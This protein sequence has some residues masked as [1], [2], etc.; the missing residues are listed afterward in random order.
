MSASI[1]FL[2]AALGL[3]QGSTTGTE[4]Q[5]PEPQAGASGAEQDASQPADFESEPPESGAP[6][7]HQEIVVTAARYEQDS[8]ETPAP[9]S[10]ISREELERR[11]PEKL[12][13][14][15]KSLPGIEV[16]GEGPFRGL[17]VIRG[18]TSNRILI[19][20]DGQRLNNG[21]ESTEFAGIQPGLVDLSQ[22]E[23][24]EVLRGP[25]SVLYGSD[26]LGGVVNIIT[27]ES[28]FR[29][30]GFRLRGGG[31]YS[32]GS[33]ADT[34]RGRVQLGGE[35]ARANFLI[36]ATYFDAENYES[37]EGE[38]PNSQAT[39]HSFDATARFMLAENRFVRTDL[40]LFRARDIGF[41]GFDPATS[42]VDIAFPKFER[43]KFS[44]T[45]EVTSWRALR[46]LSANFYYQNT[47]KDTKRNFN[48]GPFFFSNN[49]TQSD[50]D[51]VGVN[52]QSSAELGAHRLTFGVDFYRDSL[53]DETFAESTFGSSTNV[54]VPDSDQ[55]AVGVFVQ[56]EFP[57]GGRLHLVVGARADRFSFV[58][59]DD[60]DYT[61][62]PFDETQSDISGNFGARYL[63]TDHVELT[64]LVGR[65]FRAPNI[66]ERS[67]FGL[68]TTGDT[69]IEQNPNL[70]SERS[71]NV[72][73]G[74]KV[75]YEKYFGGFSYFHNSIRDLI[76]TV[77]LG[78]DPNSGLQLA[79]FDNIDEATIQGV[80]LELQRFLGPR[81]SV[82][83]NFSYT[84]GTNETSGEPLAL[85]PPVKLVAGGRYQVRSWWGEL[86]GRLVSDQDRV[87]SALEPSE[88][89]T[90]FDVR[91]GYDLAD[92]VGL[93]IALEN[94]ADEAYAEPFNERLEPGR[95]LRVSL[96][97]NF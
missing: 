70:D 88:S 94:L 5:D 79:R 59:Q 49:R 47:F 55:D 9:I 61:G 29:S 1:W 67:F 40:Q 33:S 18:L 37:P 23:R 75:R 58:S 80:E 16:S 71:I 90:T 74:F 4:E 10:V 46:N 87:P 86:T 15:L 28:A 43:D 7:Y 42:G 31:S 50:I 63:V 62:L 38:V 19:L 81:W 39:Q 68:A 65:G 24:I 82:F 34:Q 45:Y 2:T 54:A 57:L 89:F 85:I 96:N 26:A 41:P 53:H 76:A 8:F 12:V 22:V 48:F 95:N 69:F 66:Q 73:V 83:T 35:G 93:Q 92:G 30:G 17:P 78:T 36:G 3:F 32:F 13:D 52:A 11:R 27:R 84:R 56:D 97:Y 6:R 20:V 21:R 14:V 72:D 44:V 91:G 77:F 51:S 64:A 60:S 25:A